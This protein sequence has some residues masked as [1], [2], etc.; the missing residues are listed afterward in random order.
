MEKPTW[1]KVD[2]EFGVASRQGASYWS[3]FF[4]LEL[5]LVLNDT[6]I[7]SSN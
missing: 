6:S 3:D 5:N 2:A 1:A 4:Q 7:E